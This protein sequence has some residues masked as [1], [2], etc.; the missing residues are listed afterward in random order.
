MNKALTLFTCAAFSFAACSHQAKNTAAN[1]VGAG[2]AVA[3]SHEDDYEDDNVENEG[4]EVGNKEVIRT[5]FL[6]PHYVFNPSAM[7]GKK[8][9]QMMRRQFTADG[10]VIF[11]LCTGTDIQQSAN[12]GT[13]FQIESCQLLGRAEGYPVQHVNSVHEKLSKSYISEA[14]KVVG[15]VVGGMAIGIASGFVLGKIFRVK[16]PFTLPA[17][18]A[19]V[20]L[21]VA[22]YLA[23]FSN[24]NAQQGVSAAP[25]SAPSQ[26]LGSNATLYI[27]SCPDGDVEKMAKSAVLKLEN[28]MGK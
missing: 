14:Y 24:L 25:E 19:P 18:G 27:V 9:I 17:L 15:K 23:D 22:L 21:G 11:S 20:G 2:R 5:E 16:N 26:D 13:E 10:K 12:A 6:A 28:A 4:N 7:S 3:Q 8:T 1:S